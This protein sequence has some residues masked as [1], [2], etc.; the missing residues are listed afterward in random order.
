MT[1]I[2]LSENIC[3]VQDNKNVITGMTMRVRLALC[4]HYCNI[5]TFGLTGI[6]T[7]HMAFTLE[8]EQT[9]QLIDRTVTIPYWVGHCTLLQL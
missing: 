5:N 3:M 9:L 4:S 2:T 7:H 8:M 1:S 6:M